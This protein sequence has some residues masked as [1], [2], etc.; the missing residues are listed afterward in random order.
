ME[1]A[2]PRSPVWARCLLW[3]SLALLYLPLVYMICGSFFDEG[4]GLNFTLR[5]YREI[6]ED[7]V[8]QEAL[9]RSLMIAFCNGVVST[10]FGTMAAVALLKSEFLGKKVLQGLS[11]MSLVMP[12]LVF[13]LSL[14]SWFF[15]LK[16]E[17]SFLT[18]LIA[19]V[20]FSLAFVILT[21]KSR[22]S[23]LDI[24][25]ED[26]A[27]DLGASEWTILFKVTL[28]LL[29]PALGTAFILVF[30]LSFDDF[31]ITFFNSGAGSDT[32]P[33]KLY[34]AMRLGHTP[35]LNA[36]ATLMIVFSVGLILSISRSRGFQDLWK[37]EEK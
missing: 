9:G 21:V 18:V 19:H 1:K 17:L 11:T 33:I 20:T 3:L 14:L 7:Y 22:L 34:S 26:A 6:I 36:M 25:I 2:R 31:L 13:A 28:P 16:F 8:L 5:W 15:I 4:E 30:L 23:S 12:E 29:K 32:L 35:K 10:T 27:K 24:S 37:A